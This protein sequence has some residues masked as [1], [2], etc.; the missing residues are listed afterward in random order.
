MYEQQM[1]R[2]KS[3]FPDIIPLSDELIERKPADTTTMFEQWEQRALQRIGGTVLSA[4]VKDSQ[5][6]SEDET[7]VRG[8]N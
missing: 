7:F 5:Q 8:Y 4:D 6:R 1:N 2:K 3:P